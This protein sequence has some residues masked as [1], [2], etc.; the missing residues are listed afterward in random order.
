MSGLPQELIDRIIDLVND[1]ET[2]KACSLI[3]SQW[4]PRSRKYLFAQ[5]E[6][7]SQTDLERWCARTRPG[8]S[9]L[10]PLVEV[11]TLSGYHPSF[12]SPSSLWLR[13]SVSILTDATSHFQSFSALRALEVQRW[14]MSTDRMPSILHSFSSSLENVTRLTLGDVTIRS[15]TLGMFVSHF[16]RLDNLS[17]SAIRTLDDTG[18]LY[19]GFRGEI[20]PTHP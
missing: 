17:I 7:T 9:G 1:R 12:T 11:L 10:S 16:P 8:R 6:F 14:Y 18:D 4:S 5:V 13:S 19:P 2:L 3:C 15:P 20:V